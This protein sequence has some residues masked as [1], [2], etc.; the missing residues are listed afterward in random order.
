[1]LRRQLPFNV[2]GVIANAVAVAVAIIILVAFG[3]P[4]KAQGAFVIVLAAGLLA[5]VFLATAVSVRRQ[6]ALS[7]L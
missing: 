1:M 5:A 3:D 7:K 6:R 4:S 2:I